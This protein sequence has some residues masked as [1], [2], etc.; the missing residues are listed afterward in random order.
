MAPTASSLNR[1]LYF[2][3]YRDGGRVVR[4]VPT[5]CKDESSARSV[6]A[7]LERR[8]ELVKAGVVTGAEADVGKHREKPLADHFAAYVA[9][10]DS[11][12]TTQAHRDN[13]R[14]FLDRIA[15]DCSFK[16]LSDLKREALERW[17]TARTKEGISSQTSKKGMSART[18][19]AYRD[20]AVSFGNWLVESGRDLVNPFANAPRADKRADPRRQR[21]S[22]TEAELVKLL[23]V[24]RHRPLVDARTVRRGEQAGKAVADLKPETTERLDR[25]GRERA[26]LYKA[27]VLTGLRKNELASLTVGKLD[28]DGPIPFASLAAADEKNRQGSEIVLRDD[29]AA[30]LREWLA[31]KLRLLQT[32]AC[33]TW[34][35]IPA[36]LPA[37]TPVF[38]VP[39]GLVRILDRDLKAAKIPKR[40]ERGRTLDVHALRTTFGTLLSK[41]GV[42]PRTAQA[43]MRHS[44]IR[45]TM[46]TYTDP[47]LLD[48]RGALDSLPGLPLSSGQT[49]TSESARA[50]GT[51]DLRRNPLAP[52]LAPTAGYSGQKGSS[53]DNSTYPTI[54]TGVV[55]DRSVTSLP[56]NRK[57]P[58]TSP[59]SEPRSRGERIRTSDLLVPN[60]A[61]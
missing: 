37:D 52:P 59:V 40:D 33:R 45:L 22:M 46:Q 8:A 7:E 57:G 30:D 61:I 58:L 49:T 15:G 24:A 35:P 53:E 54:A 5:G 47:K 36:K 41:G 18:R 43:A 2:A 27:L 14:R 32:D 38:T 55:G 56:V 4:V 26:L 44:D 11:K 21:R 16:L 51:D 23:N 50:T 10:L 25:L 42:A 29:L 13:V 60:Q 34:A 12:G 20:A 19:N 1:P 48:V 9:H 31:E 39:A 17:L 6:L 28:L 3:K